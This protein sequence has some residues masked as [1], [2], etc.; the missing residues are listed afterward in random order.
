MLFLMS[1]GKDPASARRFPISSADSLAA[2]ID[3][4]SSKWIESLVSRGRRRPLS[5]AR[6]AACI[7]AKKDCRLDALLLRVFRRPMSA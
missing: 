6:E 5:I 1:F 3:Q 4:R 7:E 2:L